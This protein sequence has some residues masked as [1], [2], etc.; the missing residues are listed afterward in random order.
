MDD[1]VPRVHDNGAKLDLE[2]LF[3]VRPRVFSILR[4]KLD[5]VMGFVI[6]SEPFLIRLDASLCLFSR[7]ISFRLSVLRLLFK[8][9]LD[10]L[11]HFGLLTWEKYGDLQSHEIPPA[12]RM[13]FP[14]LYP[15]GGRN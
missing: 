5:P 1:G 6:P 13:S 10:N 8:S 11:F 4:A 12:A 3:T 7:L 14:S 2:H 9:S 15:Q